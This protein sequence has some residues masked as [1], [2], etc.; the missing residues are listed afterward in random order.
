MGKRN[1]KWNKKHANRHYN[2]RKMGVS[3]QS[4]SKCSVDGCNKKKKRTISINSVSGYISKL[5]WKLEDANKRR[6]VSLCK[7]HYKEYS[8]LKK[9]EEKYKRMRDYGEAP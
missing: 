7:K 9:K 2:R 1:P 3:D 8:K 4:S 6:K 5:G